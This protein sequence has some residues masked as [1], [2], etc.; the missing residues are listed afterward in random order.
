MFGNKKPPRGGVRATKNPPQP[1]QQNHRAPDA[2]SAQYRGQKDVRKGYFKG[3]SAALSEVEST[4]DYLLV[5]ADFTREKRPKSRGQRSFR[6]DN[7]TNTR[8]ACAPQI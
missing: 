5:T 8:D 3:K 7:E 6:G 2:V 4:S 1:T